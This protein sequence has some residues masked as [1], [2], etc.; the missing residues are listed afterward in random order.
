VTA[1]TTDPTTVTNPDGSTTT[2]LTDEDT[3]VVTQ[4]TTGTVTDEN[5]AETETTTVVATAP[6]GT[7]TTEQT[8][9][10]T[11]ADGTTATTVTTTDET[12]AA[13]TKAEVNISQEAAAAAAESGEVV[14][15]PI[16]VSATKADSEDPA[17]TVSLSIPEDA[18]EVTVEIPVEDVTPGTVVVLVHEDGT[19]EIVKLSGLTDDG[20]TLNVSGNVTVKVVDNSKDFAD[21]EDHWAE[22]AIDF[23][24]SRELFNG[25][26]D[27]TEFAPDEPMSRAMLVTVLARLNDVDTTTGSTWDEVGLN[28]AKEKGISD[29]S[30]ATADVT[31]EQMVAML[32]RLAGSP[33]VSGSLSAF[34]DA[35]QVSSYAADAMTWAVSVGIIGGTGAGT[36]LP[37]GN[38]SRSEVATILQRFVNV[39]MK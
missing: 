9:Q 10:T 25:V 28:W 4:T 38:A 5:G 31:R 17:T 21:T 6:D 27:G 14:T 8:V 7:T 2:T 24:T 35:D 19:E 36:L 39:L 29:G 26:G 22:D 13:V 20:V 37:A 12:G 15:L 1:S 33:A 34:P 16:S 23:V 32:Y 18:G 3:G 30:N 11:A